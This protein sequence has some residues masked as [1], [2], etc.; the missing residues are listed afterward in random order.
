MVLITTV[1]IS[2]MLKLCG[3]LCSA[4]KNAAFGLSAYRRAREGRELWRR[5]KQAAGLAGT[6][7]AL[8]AKLLPL[9]TRRVVKKGDGVRWGQTIA[10]GDEDKHQLLAFQCT[11]HRQSL[12]GAICLFETEHVGQRRRR[13]DF[14]SCLQVD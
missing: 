3:D 13:Q 10:C 4:R 9:S 2:L 5:R 8:A 11:F 12:P 6:L 7:E 14:F 1:Q